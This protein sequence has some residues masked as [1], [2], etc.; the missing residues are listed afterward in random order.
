MHVVA[1]SL[2]TGVHVVMHMVVVE[3][4]MAINYNP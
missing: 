2:D 1:G 3:Q 4:E